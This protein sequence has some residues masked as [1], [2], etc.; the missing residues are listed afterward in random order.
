MISSKLFHAQQVNIYYFTLQE[1]KVI[2]FDVEQV[3][4]KIPM[5]M[6]RSVL[7]IFFLD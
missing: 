3:L 7:F 1:L 5:F 2:V 6:I 4:K